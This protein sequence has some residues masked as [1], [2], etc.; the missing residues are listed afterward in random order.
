MKK[1]GLKNIFGFLN[2]SVFIYVIIILF[3]TKKIYY[4]ILS[5]GYNLYLLIYEHTTKYFFN[6]FIELWI[7]VIYIIFSLTLFIILKIKKRKRDDK[8]EKMNRINSFFKDVFKSGKIKTGSIFLY[9]VISVGFLAPLLAPMDPYDVSNS[10]YLR[11]RQPFSSVNFMIMEKIEFSPESIDEGEAPAQA[12]IINY[13]EELFPAKTKIYFDSISYSDDHIR[14]YQ[15]NYHKDISLMQMGALNNKMNKQI[16]ILGTDI[17]GRD[18]LS[19]IIYGTRISL[20]IGF[21]SLIISM[22][23]GVFIGLFSGFKGGVLDSI[24]MRFVDIVLSFPILFLIL[25]IIGLFG[26][27][28]FLIILF[29]GLTTWMDIARLVRTQVMSIKNENYILAA[30]ALGFSRLRILFRHILPNVLTPIIINA[31]FRIGNIILSESAL[32][33]LGIGVQPPAASWGNII[34]EGKEYILSAWW[35]SLFPGL[36]ITLTV[37]SFNIIGERMREKVGIER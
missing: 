27:S 5:L 11:N 9:T 34:N 16:H 17:F 33:F 4:G 1:T 24:L 6:E 25:L 23:I 36:L 28:V 21:L 30:G 32:S 29:L 3:N 22:I 13:K 10:A 12:S 2:I 31:T 35:I 7:A 8:Y 14:F 26:N 37:L 15:G 20:S 18:L 19:R